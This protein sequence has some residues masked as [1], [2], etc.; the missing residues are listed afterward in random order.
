[1]QTALTHETAGEAIL[2]LEIIESPFCEK[3][4]IRKEL[5]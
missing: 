5:E 1:M 4:R 2:P 3:N